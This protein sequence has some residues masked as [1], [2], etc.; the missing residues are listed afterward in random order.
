MKWLSFSVYVPR[1]YNVVEDHRFFLEGVYFLLA[2]TTPGW[3]ILVSSDATSYKP[4]E[5]KGENAS[6]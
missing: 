4:E 3:F 6:K 5:R 1:Y 2:K